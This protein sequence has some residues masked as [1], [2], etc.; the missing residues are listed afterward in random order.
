MLVDDVRRCSEN[1]VT[2]NYNNNNTKNAIY[3][4]IF[5]QSLCTVQLLDTSYLRQQITLT[6]GWKQLIGTGQER[7]TLLLFLRFFC[8]AV[9]IEKKK[10]KIPSSCKNTTEYMYHDCLYSDTIQQYLEDTDPIGSDGGKNQQTLL[11][12]HME[13]SKDFV[14]RRL[15]YVR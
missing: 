3:V 6:E 4:H 12:N 11:V 9:A 8:I 2:F 7:V 13:P 15:P 1:L 14:P 10:K 5:H